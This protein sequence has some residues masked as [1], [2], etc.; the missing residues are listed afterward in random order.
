[1]TV[2]ELTRL[3]LKAKAAVERAWNTARSHF[4]PQLICDRPSSTLAVSL[5]GTKCALNCAHCGGHYL[6]GMTP[7]EKIEAALATGRYTSCLLSGGCTPAGKVEVAR[8]EELVIRLK[9]RGLKINVHAGLISQA[10][11]DVLAP[12]ADRISFDMVTDNR[13]IRDVF[14]LTRTG[15][16]YIDTYRRLRAAGACVVPHICVGLWGGQVRGEYDALRVLAE[17]GVDALVFIVLIP[18]PG[19]AFADRQPPPLEDVANVF[20]RARE[21]FP[22]QSINLGCMRPTGRYRAELD[23]LAVASG[24]NRLVNPTPPALRLARSLG[25][26]LIDRKECCVL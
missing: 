15:D 19:T 11:I 5:T 2:D 26:E 22:R 23:T 21:L 16:D 8:Q 4:P 10:E 24:L 3:S 17:L 6:E 7:I 14:G 12:L 18:T 25:L 13:T 20:A 9:S 1:M